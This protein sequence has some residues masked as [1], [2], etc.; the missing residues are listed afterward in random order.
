MGPLLS[1][2]SRKM[3]EKAAK[4][5]ADPTKILIHSTHDTCLAGLSST[6][7]IFDER[8]ML[9]LPAVRTMPDW[10]L[11]LIG[12][13]RSLPRS[14]SSCSRS[15]TRLLRQR[16]HGRTS[17]R[18]WGARRTRPTTVSSR[19]S[20]GNEATSDSFILADVRVRYQNENKALPF[21]AEEGKHLSGSPEFCTLAAFAERVRELTPKNWET[22]CAYVPGNKQ[23]DREEA[24][25]AAEKV[26]S[27]P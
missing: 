1:D 13:L 25:A 15:A 3:Q 19:R 10:P 21:C 16:R 11:P 12:G 17:C 6:L 24:Q 8:Y 5:D 23:R 2:L 9:R 20:V 7:D 4:G 14:R 26:I 18:C 22:E 27:K